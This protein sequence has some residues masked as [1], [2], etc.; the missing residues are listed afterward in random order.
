MNGHFSFLKYINKSSEFYF[1][2]QL[3]TN[4]WFF[5]LYKNKLEFNVRLKT[6]YTGS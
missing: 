6:K 3:K 5:S 2:F 1:S 4:G